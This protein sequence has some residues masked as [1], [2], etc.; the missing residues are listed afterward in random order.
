M[1]HL[2]IARMII[3]AALLGVILLPFSPQAR[4]DSKQSNYK[5]KYVEVEELVAALNDNDIT[6]IE[7]LRNVMLMH[8]RSHR[9]E[10]LFLRDCLL[11]GKFSRPAWTLADV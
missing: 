4:P 5:Q 9:K 11:S 3:S 7:E 1:G 2:R 8:L 6:K 10:L